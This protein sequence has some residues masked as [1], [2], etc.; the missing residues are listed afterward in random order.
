MQM[1]YSIALA[2]HEKW[3]G[4]GYPQGLEGEQIPLVARLCS[5]CDVFDALISRRPYKE[6]WPPVAAME[7]IERQSGKAFDPRMVDLFGTIL[8][9]VEFI[10]QDL[11]AEEQTGGSGVTA[12]S[13]PTTS[14]G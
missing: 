10:V 1:A 4:S 9:E 2:H 8:A 13:A 3:N 6:P 5:V 12:S 11:A 7:E 14:R